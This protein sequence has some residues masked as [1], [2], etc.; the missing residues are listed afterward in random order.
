MQTHSLE[1]VLDH[2][3]LHYVEGTV[4]NS[5]CSQNLT[6]LLFVLVKHYY[7]LGA[8]IFP[9]EILV[10]TTSKVLYEKVL[11]EEKM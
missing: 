2:D 5:H 11:L 1:S 9:S 8:E 3:D 10:A 4:L 6:W 7:F